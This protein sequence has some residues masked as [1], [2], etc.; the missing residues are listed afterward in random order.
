MIL[1]LSPDTDVITTHIA[2]LT[3]YD[4]LCVQEI[5]LFSFKGKVWVFVAHITIMSTM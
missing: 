4:R 1:F 2:Q 3:K 5:E